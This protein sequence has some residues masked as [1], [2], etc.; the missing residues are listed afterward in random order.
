MNLSSTNLILTYL[1]LLTYSYN[2][3]SMTTDGVHVQLYSTICDFGSIS[4]FQRYS[5]FIVRQKKPIRIRNARSTERCRAGVSSVPNRATFIVSRSYAAGNH[6][7]RRTFVNVACS[8]AFDI[9]YVIE[10]AATVV[11]WNEK[12]ACDASLCTCCAQKCES[13]IDACDRLALCAL[14]PLRLYTS[15]TG[16]GSFNYKP[17]MTLW[18][19]ISCLW[20]QLCLRIR[21][22]RIKHLSLNYWWFDQCNADMKFWLLSSLNLFRTD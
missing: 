5:L 18:P 13:Q 14:G 22:L 12:V 3:I 20:T 11:F 21:P 2:H 6:W 15:V 16:V 9:R 17:I 1:L 7:R 8:L 10:A 19:R 4:V